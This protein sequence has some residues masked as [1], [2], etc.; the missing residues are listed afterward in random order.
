MSNSYRKFIGRLT[1]YREMMNLSQK[2]AGCLVGKTQS[3]QSKMERG[4]TIVSYEILQHMMDAGWD[5]DFLMTGK[6]RIHIENSLSG[7]LF[8]NMGG[9]W[10]NIKEALFWI[11]GVELDKT[12]NLQDEETKLEFKLMKEFLAGTESDSV[13]HNIRNIMGISQF[14]MADRLGVNIKKYRE[15]EKGGTEPDA[16]L[17]ILIY[18]LSGCRPS[19]FFRQDDVEEYVL[20]CLWN[21]LNVERQKEA[22]EFIDYVIKIYKG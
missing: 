6:N 1:S 17:L 22:R 2:D 13:I 7:Y 3:Q 4:E 14:A 12:G 18:E 15:L 19:T 21:R 20:D 5:I 10:G 9:Y 16:E 11:I 8:E